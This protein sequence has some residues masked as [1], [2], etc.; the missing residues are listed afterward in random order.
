LENERTEADDPGPG[1][2]AEHED[3]APRAARLGPCLVVGAEPPI[4]GVKPIVDLAKRFPYLFEALFRPIGQR[5]QHHP[6]F[7]EFAF[8]RGHFISLPVP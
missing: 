2:A 3:R 4:A 8:G 5:L 1:G 6:E 7:A